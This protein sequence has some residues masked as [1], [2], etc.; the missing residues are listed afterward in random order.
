MGGEDNDGNRGQIRIAIELRE[1]VPAVEERHQQVQEQETG[2][3]GATADGAEGLA[4]A[5]DVGDGEA[6]ALEQR[7]QP[8]AHLVVVVDDEHGAT[9]VQ[10]RHR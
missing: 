3:H 10:R 2:A 1:D 9:V 4:A 5:G 8:D 6:S 7:L